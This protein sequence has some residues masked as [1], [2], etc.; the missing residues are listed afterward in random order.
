M[1]EPR[2]AGT[3]T[4]DTCLRPLPVIHFA[5]D[6]QKAEGLDP[7]CRSCRGEGSVTRR[8]RE[9]PAYRCWDW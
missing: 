4:C 2:L 3:K 8:R 5:V 7:T 1:P 6:R 9:N